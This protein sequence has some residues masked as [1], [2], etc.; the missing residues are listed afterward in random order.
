MSL[1]P[2]AQG[3]RR[4]RLRS[5]SRR[6]PG[7]RQGMA[8]ATGSAQQRPGSLRRPA[9]IGPAP[10]QVAVATLWQG[11]F[12]LLLTPFLCA[13]QCLCYVSSTDVPP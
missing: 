8:C 11:V 12:N 7:M 5:A 9:D 10:L 13:E 1:A 2:H 6:G 3:S 4:S